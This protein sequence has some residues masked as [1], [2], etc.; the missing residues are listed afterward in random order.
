MGV[1]EEQTL[2]KSQKQIEQLGLGAIAHEMTVG[3]PKQH[4]ADPLKSTQPCGCDDGAN[5][6]CA[7]HSGQGHKVFG[8]IY[9]SK[10]PS[11]YSGDSAD[12]PY[13]EAHAAKMDGIKDSGKRQ[14][15]SSGAMRDPSEGKIDWTRITF[16]PLL[17]RWALHLTKAEAKY[18]D[19]ALGVPN[20][21]LIETKE[22]LLRY[23][24]S[25]FR[26]FMSWYFDETDEDHAAATTFNIN[27][28]EIIKAK[29]RGEATDNIPAPSEMKRSVETCK[30]SS[31]L[32]YEVGE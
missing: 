1:W 26:H 13:I 6:K 21:A 19:A 32:A 3:I 16:G 17:R 24:K 9:V 28:V 18:P 23:K 15:Y 29:M 4:N 20:F 25:A 30:G 22:E 31:T 2:E 11:P 27:G 12:A 14:V 10:Q 8:S 5:Y 7:W